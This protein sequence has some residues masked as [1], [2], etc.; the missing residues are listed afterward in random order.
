MVVT[1]GV[2][3]LPNNPAPVVV[4]LV[5]EGEH[6]K[7]PGVLLLAAG[8]PNSLPPT[9]GEPK[10]P[11][12]NVAVVV[13]VP[14]S[15]VPLLFVSCE[16]PNNPPAPLDDGVLKRPDCGADVLLVAGVPNSPEPLLFVADEFPNNPPVEGGVLKSA[17]CCVDAGGVPNNPPP[18]PVE[19]GVLKRPD[20]CVDADVP[21][22]PPVTFGVEV[23]LKSV[24]CTG[25][26]PN[27]PEPVDAVADLLDKPNEDDVA[28]LELNNAVCGVVIVVVVVV[29]LVVEGETVMATLTTGLVAQLELPNGPSLTELLL[30]NWKSPCETDDVVEGATD[31]FCVAETNPLLI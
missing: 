19:D 20:F 11:V 21:N 12:C 9:E 26:D 1:T 5:E 4:E 6:P 2:A 27:N 17:D 31:E 30:D 29:V 25:G 14:N 18:P 3:E 10:S 13:G 24:A 7:S 23:E 16:F 22:N 8:V 28:F 15:P